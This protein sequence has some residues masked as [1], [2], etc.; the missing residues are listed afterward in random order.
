MV[1]PDHVWGLSLAEDRIWAQ[2]SGLRP[3]RAPERLFLVLQ[4]Y[5]DDSTQGDV[6]V[7]A[8]YLASA[9]EWAAFSREWEAM[10]PLASIQEDGRYRFKMSEMAS[11]P[12]RMS[13][14][15]G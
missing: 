10:L 4:A 9:A 5:I 7:L 11:S 2:V 14:V 6:F 3:S 8:G 15:S 12:E 13:R 1:L